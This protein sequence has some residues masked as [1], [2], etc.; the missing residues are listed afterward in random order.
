M[1]LEPV[2]ASVLRMC[3]GKRTIEAIVEQFAASHRLSFREAQLPVTQFVRQLMHR[4]VVA[5][6]GTDEKASER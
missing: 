1:E 6:V 5:V 2:G 3:D 4:G